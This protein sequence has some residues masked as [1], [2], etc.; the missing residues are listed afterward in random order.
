VIQRWGLVGAVSRDFLTY[1][2]RV[3][4]HNNRRELEFLVPDTRVME[5]PPDLP[6]DQC[7]PIREHPDFASTSFPLRR[8]D[9]R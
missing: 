9:F 1:G 6:P 7:L 8:Q 4:W 2:G 3:L 5:L